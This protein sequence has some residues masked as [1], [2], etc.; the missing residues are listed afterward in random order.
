[1][2][3]DLPESGMATGSDETSPGGGKTSAPLDDDEKAVL[4]EL[5]QPAHQV[6]EPIE[7]SAQAEAAVA[8]G[9]VVPPD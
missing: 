4:E 1:M 9:S 5:Q 3:S 8:D 6:V 7:D 2:I